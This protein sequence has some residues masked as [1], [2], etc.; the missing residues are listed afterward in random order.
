MQ[1]STFTEQI[2]GQKI[3]KNNEQ[4]RKKCMP[5]EEHN[6]HADCNPEENKTYHSA[7][8]ESLLFL[9]YISICRGKEKN[10]V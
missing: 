8:V 6:R 10:I 7:H 2:I 1:D 5:E 9:F 3:Q 4:E